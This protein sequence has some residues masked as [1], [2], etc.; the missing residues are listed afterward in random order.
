MLA[1]EEIDRMI[2]A[3]RNPSD[4][5]GTK[6]ESMLVLFSQLYYLGDYVPNRVFRVELTE[7]IN[8]TSNGRVGQTDAAAIAAKFAYVCCCCCCFLKKHV[9]IHNRIAVMRHKR[10]VSMCNKTMC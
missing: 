3:T 2:N 10:P 8:A 6:N 5:N 4:E 1:Q 7:P 9:L